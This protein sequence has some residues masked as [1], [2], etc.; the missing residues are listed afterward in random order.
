MSLSES[1]KKLVLDIITCID[2]MPDVT[3]FAKT[4]L[5][6][7]V[8]LFARELNKYEKN[9]HALLTLLYLDMNM[10][11]PD[12]IPY[13]IE[14]LKQLGGVTCC[15]RAE[16]YSFIGSLYS[17]CG[18]YRNAIAY[19]KLMNIPEGHRHFPLMLY[20]IG[21]A[22]CI[23]NRTTNMDNFHQITEEGI[24]EGLNY[25]KRA[26]IAYDNPED[27]IACYELYVELLEKYLSLEKDNSKWQFEELDEE[28]V[29]LETDGNN[30]D[31]IIF[32]QE[33]KI[34]ELQN[35]I[36]ELENEGYIQV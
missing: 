10:T 21:A 24:K 32:E 31:I 33:K 30:K 4:L 16:L 17:T 1:D 3:I 36:T 8:R 28:V 14:L 27:K 7:D 6:D 15:T 23:M 35:K 25:L 5:V 20:N 12:D 2:N 18:K 26:M 29:R 22:Y 13:H 9:R 34:S 19:Y 11:L